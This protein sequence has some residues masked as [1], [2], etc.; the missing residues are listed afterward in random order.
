MPTAIRRTGLGILACL[1]TLSAACIGAIRQERSG[2]RGEER[3]ET[4]AVELHLN[5]DEGR[6]ASGRDAAARGDYP[7]ALAQFDA[8]YRKSSADPKLRA[9]ALYQSALVYNDA[10]NPRR[11]PRQ[12]AAH[13]RTLKR[14]FPESEWNDEADALLTT[15]EPPDER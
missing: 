8:V 11:D 6:I 10:L 12:A 9:Q 3:Q 4:A 13:L 2:E 5:P 14:E 1:M 7:A 15:L